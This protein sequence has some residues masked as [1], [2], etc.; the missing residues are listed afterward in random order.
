MRQEH[1]EPLRRTG[2][3]D[4][5]MLATDKMPKYYPDQPWDWVF[6]AAVYDST[7]LCWHA[8]HRQSAH[9]GIRADILSWIFEKTY[10]EEAHKAS[11][12][13]PCIRQDTGRHLPLE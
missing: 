1:F 9:S 3:A 10:P 7:G 13:R 5:A 12:E 8:S 2:E 4:V 11:F 6:A